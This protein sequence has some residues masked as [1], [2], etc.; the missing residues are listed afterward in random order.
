MRV[1]SWLLKDLSA[2]PEG[3]CFIELVREVCVAP[4]RITRNA[5]KKLTLNRE[6]KRREEDNIKM[7]FKSVL[8]YGMNQCEPG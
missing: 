5:I 4:T 3:L 2:S 7:Y 8:V 6:K 1:I